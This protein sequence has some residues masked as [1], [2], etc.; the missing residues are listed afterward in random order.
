MKIDASLA[1]VDQLLKRTIESESIV[2][3]L[4]RHV[5]QVSGKKLRAKLCLISS[6]NESNHEK[7]DNNYEEIRIQLAAIIELLH[8]A[9]LVHDDVID[10]ASQRRGQET[11]S[12]AWSNSHAVLIGDYIYSRAFVL[13][14]QIGVPEIIDELA[15]ATNKIAQ[16]E[17]IQLQNKKNWSIDKKI[18]EKINYYKTGRLFEAASKT[19]S[20]IGKR[21]KKDAN[22]LTTISKNLG[23]AFQIQDDLL[24][25]GL[26][27]IDIG[28]PK[29]QD[30]KEQKI[31]FPLMFALEESSNQTKKD[32]KNLLDSK[33]VFAE[34]IY[35]FVL[36]TSAI[37]KCNQLLDNNF[38]IT[39]EL[40]RNISDNYISLEMLNLLDEMWKRDY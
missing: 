16:G 3:D 18:L 28:K 7:F 39:Q 38:K 31:T 17:L 2:N 1:A 4:Y 40:I 10:L 19:G 12:E 22:I 5:F 33:E 35:D 14:A 9:T 30:I 34:R 23:I 8:S 20:I 13:M 11:V 29:L 27:N 6:L 37:K 25:Y 26:S 36:S 21:S 24:D 32:I 15:D